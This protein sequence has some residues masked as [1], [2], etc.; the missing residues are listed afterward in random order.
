MHL[1]LRRY[2]TPIYISNFCFLILLSSFLVPYS[3][4]L[5]PLL[6]CPLFAFLSTFSYLWFNLTPKPRLM[7]SLVKLICLALLLLS[8]V[9]NANSQP[10]LWGTTP[11]GGNTQSGTVFEFDLQDNQLE[12][13]YDFHK[14]N[15]SNPRYQ[16]LLADND[17]FYGIGEGGF[18]SFGSVIYEYDPATGD[19][20]IV[21]DFF[22]TE[23]YMNYSANIGYLM[24]ASNGKLYGYLQNGG[25]SYDGRLFE[26]DIDNYEIEFKFDFEELTKGTYPVGGLC[27][28]TDGRLYGVTHEGGSYGFGVLFAYDPIVNMY[29]VLKHF[30]GTST[31]GNPMEGVIQASNGFLYGLTLYGG[32]DDH[33]II[34]KYEIGANILSVLHEFTNSTDGGIPMGRLFQA[35]DGNLYGMTSEGGSHSMGGIFQY[36]ISQSLFIKEMDFSGANGAYPSGS[37]IEFEGFLWGMTKDGGVSNK[38]TLFRY[39]YEANQYFKLVDLY[40]EDYGETPVGNLA[41][42]PEATLFGQTFRGGMYPTS[43]IMFE[44]FP[45]TSIFEKKFDYRYAKD[46][47]TPRSSPIVSSDGMLYGTCYVDGTGTAGT[48][49]RIDPSNQNFE[50]L[51][52]FDDFTN[53]GGA[54]KGG[55]MEASNGMMYGLAFGGTYA[56][57]VLYA[58][59]P[60][61]QIVTILHSFDDAVDGTQFEGKLLE[62][63]NN[64]LY[65]TALQGGTNSD[66]VL[67]EYDLQTSTFSAIHNFQRPTSGKEPRGTPVEAANGKIYGLTEKGGLFDQGVLYEYDPITTLL[68]VVVEFDGT[69]KGYYPAGTLL[70]YEDNMLY[71]LAPAG[72]INN[73][74][75]MFVYN[76][77]TGVFTKLLD[78]DISTTGAYSQCSL[79]RASNGKIYGSTQAGCDHNFGGIFE[80][81]PST[82]ILSNLY[83]FENYN[84]KHMYDGL[85]EV[86]TDFGID[87]SSKEILSF[88]VFPN[89]AE[90]LINISCPEIEGEF[91][92]SIFD[93]SGKLT[94]TENRT[95]DFKFDITDLDSG[96]YTVQISSAN[97]TGIQKLIVN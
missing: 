39:D 84:D 7:K 93:I 74:G 63:S 6:L 52:N 8:I 60:A 22:D 40:G 46:G 1:R 26:F 44:Y 48:I 59:N 35:T 70:E 14:Y 91:Q 65:G 64:K 36:D 5:I 23:N 86:E 19:F 53:T 57:G 10:K 88:I 66:G 87:E 78:F 82:Y 97:R 69:N 34:Y 2:K 43:G 72:G 79:M 27:E 38:G 41:I 3:L 47:S 51:Y 90:N 71:G 67:F 50:V 17:K 80:F 45:A 49:Y 54:P 28:G 77:E 20:K 29:A 81:D 30:N 12:V 95:G 32:G 11:Y 68:S 85:I 9:P 92:L 15:C 76:A 89:P 42:G 25:A 73:E 58:F 56:D 31:G 21:Y 94:L 33:G 83:S 18:G 61:N 4:F 24:Q 62:A 75:V 13:I 16:L 96:I 55:L 37:L